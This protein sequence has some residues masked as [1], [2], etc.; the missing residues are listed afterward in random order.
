MPTSTEREMPLVELRFSANELELD[1]AQVFKLLKLPRQHPQAE[2]WRQ[3]IAA[4]E[5]R[6][7]ERLEPKAQ[8]RIVPI[9][10]RL[11]ERQTVVLAGEARFTGR[12]VY[13]RLAGCRHAAA[14]LLTLG[15]RLDSSLRQCNQDDPLDGYLSDCVA[16]AFTHSVL[17]RIER[18]VRQWAEARRL[19]LTPRYSPGYHGWP[20]Q[21][22]RP[23]FSLLQ[24]ETMNVKLN[25]QFFMIPQKSVSGIWGLK[26]EKA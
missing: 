23:L 21:D 16:A 19:Q 17:R 1:L 2:E 20:L 3:R 6:V 18:E 14:F 9:E 12:G 11:P 7:R 5:P 24:T 22:Q 10:A 15:H 25:D 26:P 8:Y 4:V 13:R